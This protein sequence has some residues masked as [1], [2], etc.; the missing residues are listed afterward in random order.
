MAQSGTNHTSHAGGF[1][2]RGGL[3]DGVRVN[4]EKG[5]QA[6]VG[7]VLYPGHD[8]CDACTEGCA[9]GAM[10]GVVPSPRDDMSC[11]WVRELAV[12]M[13]LAVHGCT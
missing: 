3:W 2:G 11:C 8:T 13:L 1:I 9:A 4:E 7:G 10:A 12:R 5:A 6:G